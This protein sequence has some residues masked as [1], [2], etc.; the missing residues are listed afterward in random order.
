M[1]YVQS[2]MHNNLAMDRRQEELTNRRMRGRRSPVLRRTPIIVRGIPGVSGK[3]SLSAKS[4][5]RSSSRDKRGS[6]K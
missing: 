6:T 5:A 1:Q 3:L 2:K 4:R